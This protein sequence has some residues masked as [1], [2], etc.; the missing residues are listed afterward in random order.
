M[1]QILV[2]T[3]GLPSERPHIA[4]N[5][6]HLEDRRVQFRYGILYNGYRPKLFWWELTIAFAVTLVLIA[7]IFG[8]RLG[9]DMQ[10]M[11]A[12]LLSCS[13]DVTSGF[14]TVYP[15]DQRA[16]PEVP[17]YILEEDAGSIW[18]ARRK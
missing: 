5:R 14:Q 13:F 10:V 3:V 11:I 18:R 7:G 17:D 9:P 15:A 8:V 16:L 4:Q 1:P 12:L 2:Y 6:K